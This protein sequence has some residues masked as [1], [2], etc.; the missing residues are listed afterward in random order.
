MAG[1]NG[2]YSFSGLTNGMY[3]VT[4]QRSGYVFEPFVQGVSIAGSSASNVNFTAGA[5]SPHTVTLRWQ[6]STSVVTGYNVYRGIRSG[7]P[8]DKL[9]LS[10]VAASSYTDSDLAV[11]T[12]YYYVTTAVNG[13]GEESIYSNQ[14]SVNIP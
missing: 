13:T 9:N 12:T 3:A 8:Y 2:S 6:P 11:T 14:V 5:L 1:S 7:G 4:P 10:L